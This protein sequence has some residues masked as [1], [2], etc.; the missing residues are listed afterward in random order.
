MKT[1]LLIAGT[2]YYPESGTGDWIGCYDSY[3]DA[4]KEIAK[5]PTEPRLFLSGPRKGQVNPN[6][7]PKPE[8]IEIKGQKYDWYEI[9]DLMEWMRK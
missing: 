7:R 3:E 9:V 1:Y 2:H 6:K 5:I 4:N 8:D